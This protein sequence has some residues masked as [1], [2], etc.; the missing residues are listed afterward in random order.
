MI[1]RMSLSFTGTNLK[2]CPRLLASYAGGAP[3]SGTVTFLSSTCS[4]SPRAHYSRVS[5]SWRPDT[6]NFIMFDEYHFLW[7]SRRASLMPGYW[8]D[9]RL[10]QL[11]LCRGD[12]AWASDWTRE[13]NFQASLC[14]DWLYSLSTAFISLSVWLS[15][16]KGLRKN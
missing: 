7:K 4:K 2:I 11:N 8:R 10:P 16:S 14:K 9:F 12:S 6:H 13:K 3:R 15:P 5:K 1:E